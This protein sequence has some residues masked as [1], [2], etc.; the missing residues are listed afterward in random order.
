MK[1]MT[2]AGNVNRKVQQLKKQEQRLAEDIYALMW[3]KQE[4][5]APGGIRKKAA[6]LIESPRKY[7]EVP[8]LL[9]Q[10]LLVLKLPYVFQL[11]QGARMLMMEQAKA[12]GEKKPLSDIPSSAEEVCLGRSGR[13]TFSQSPDSSLPLKGRGKV[14]T[15]KD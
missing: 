3:L 5:T 10:T 4:L 14:E 6:A 1:D 11:M 8:T 2:F 9:R 15:L 13:L 12:L 7:T